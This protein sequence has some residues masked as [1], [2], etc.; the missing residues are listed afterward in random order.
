MIT[1][2]ASYS[3]A[4]INN[5]TSYNITVS[6]QPSGQTCTVT[7]GSG[8]V[9]S[10]DVTNVNVTCSTIVTYSV[11]GTVSGLA[12]S[13]TLRNNGANDKVI[14]TDTSYSFTGLTNGSGYN[15]TIYSQPSGQTCT[16]T[17]NFGTVSSANVTNIAVSC[18]VAT[19]SGCDITVIQGLPLTVGPIT[20]GAT[21][22]FGSLAVGSSKTFNFGVG[23]PGSGTTTMTNSPVVVLSNTT[24]FTISM[25]PV[26]P[27]GSS[28]EQMKIV[29][30][31]QSSGTKSSTV[32]I[33]NNTPSNN[34]F[35]FT[36]TGN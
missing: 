18:P 1:T 32:S 16:I 35:T 29:F 5:G 11:G 30:N 3:F 25:Y 4:S 7:N 20:N 14:T 27:L 34:P 10:A 24:D 22:F 31:P 36:V 19:C 15:V 23:N 28:T 8:T 2:N 9:S 13:L 33:P 21:V 17:N 26:N 6:S 12:G